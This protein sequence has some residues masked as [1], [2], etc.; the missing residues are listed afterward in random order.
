[1]V[2]QDVSNTAAWLTV[3][4]PLDLPRNVRGKSQEPVPLQVENVEFQGARNRVLHAVPSQFSLPVYHTGAG[5]CET[6]F[7][8]WCHCHSP[9]LQRAARI[10]LTC[11]HNGHCGRIARLLRHLG[12]SRVL[13]SQP[14]AEGMAEGRDRTSPC[15][16]AS[17]SAPDE[18]RR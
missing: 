14:A 17:G 2:R 5:G 4:G 1:V 3:S 11:T 12:F 18:A 7:A 16:P 9:H 6:W 10:Q 15:G 8:D 13:R